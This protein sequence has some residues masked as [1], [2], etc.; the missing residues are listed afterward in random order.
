MRQESVE[1]LFICYDLLGFQSAQT[2]PLKFL[3]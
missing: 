3:K 2:T 1:I